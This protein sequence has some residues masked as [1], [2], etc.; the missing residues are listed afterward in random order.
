MGEVLGLGVLH[1]S[2][3]GQAK[4]RFEKVGGGFYKALI[5]VLMPEFSEE[6]QEHITGYRPRD[7]PK[8]HF[9]CIPSYLKLPRKGI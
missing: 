9:P 6:V 8:P 7:Y 2:V 4:S 5:F 1:V 3:F